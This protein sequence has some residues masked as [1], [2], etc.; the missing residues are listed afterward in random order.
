MVIL[1]AILSAGILFLSYQFYFVFK[2]GRALLKEIQNQQAA[3]D[4]LIHPQN[5]TPFKGRVIRRTDDVLWKEE[6]NKTKILS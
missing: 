5:V 2:S 3:M 1:L 4:K 6:S